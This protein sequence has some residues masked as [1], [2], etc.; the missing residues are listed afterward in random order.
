MN[1]LEQAKP[2][3]TGNGFWLPALPLVL[4]SASSIRSR[5]LTD[6]AIPHIV[7][8]ANIDERKLEKEISDGERGVPG[9]ASQLARAKALSVSQERS[10]AYVLGADQTCVLGNS[11]LHKPGSLAELLEQLRAMRGKTHRLYSAAAIARE[12]MILSECHAHAELTLRPFSEDFLADYVNLGG[13]A[14]L[15]SVGGYQIEK[16]GS[17][18]FSRVVG[19]PFTIMGLPMIELLED[20]RSLKLIK[21]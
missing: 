17:V 14:L 6:V 4:A 1:L 15:G 5:L 12:G 2:G 13:S 10:E 7:V 21:T 16:M 11:L 9:L 19:D 20:L 8:P 3:I 18:L